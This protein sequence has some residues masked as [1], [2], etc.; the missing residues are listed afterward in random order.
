MKLI[1]PEQFFKSIK[2][3]KPDIDLDLVKLA[4]EFAADAH[5]H[6]RRQ[7]G[8][9]FV[10][11]SMNIAQ[12]LSELKL[13]QT[14]IIAGL[15]HDV[16]EDT[17]ISVGALEKEFGE[18]IASLIVGVTKLKKIRY[19]GLERY[20]ENLRKMFLAMAEDIRAIFI[21]LCDRIHN[22]STLHALPKEKQMRIA[23]ESLEIYASIADRLGIGVLKG[24]IED[25]AFPFVYPKE[26]FNIK[27]L[28]AEKVKFKQPHVENLNEALKKNLFHAGYKDF[29]IHSRIKHYYSLW[30]KMQRY[31]DN[32]DRIYDL[33]ASRIIVK[34]VG[35]C[36]ACLGLI[37]QYWKPLPGRIKDYIAQPKTNGY[38]SLHTTI[39]GPDNQYIEIQIRSEKM[40]NEAEYGAAAHWAYTESGK[41]PVLMD[42]KR[43]EWV[44]QL[45]RF[46]KEANLKPEDFIKNLKFDFFQ[47]RIFVFTPKGDVI[48]L[49][50]GSTPIDFAYAIHSD[51]GNSCAQVIVND[52]IAALNTKLKNGDIVRVVTDKNRRLPSADWLR[53][54]QTSLAKSKI[55]DAVKASRKR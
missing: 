8:E 47:D 25:L 26:Y 19:R 30:R 36:Y 53:I 35:E 54:A 6:Q 5:Q 18:E 48:D 33:V 14:T 55:K 34:D 28:F 49:P 40:H 9:P 20:V 51:I 23:L 32:I 43:Y 29:G 2:K 13:D 38:Q 10:Q 44:S 1:T 17:E 45:L 22:L 50:D 7:T 27:K 15:L 46:Q 37:H 4:Y 41:K 21:K 31:D 24:K 12:Q 16:V 11:H 3:N 39:F 52:K 42:G